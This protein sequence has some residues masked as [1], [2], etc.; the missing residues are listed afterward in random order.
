MPGVQL[1]AF[2][3]ALRPISTPRRGGATPTAFNLLVREYS[4][5]RR[6]GAP[7][8]A[9]RPAKRAPASAR[10]AGVHG[11]LVCDRRCSR[12]GFLVTATIM[13]LVG[14]PLLSWARSGVAVGWVLPVPGRARRYSSSR[15]AARD[16]DR[17]AGTAP[18]YRG[19]GTLRRQ[20]PVGLGDLRPLPNPAGASPGDEVRTSPDPAL[21]SLHFQVA[22][23][24]LG[25]DRAK[26]STG[27]PRHGPSLPR[28][29][30]QGPPDR[31]LA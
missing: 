17:G 8:P 26:G 6:R 10:L 13:A 20:A 1:I 9:R 21:R 16:P 7:A 19:G 27:A 2:P 15:L 12:A 18:T 30:S 31:H 23:D 25:L 14:A 11:D 3:A 24:D 29:G 4:V 22:G 28:G 5:P